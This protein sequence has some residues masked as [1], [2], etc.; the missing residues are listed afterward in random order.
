MIEHVVFFKLKSMEKDEE[1]DLINLVTSLKDKISSI[2]ELSFGRTFQTE[3]AKGYTHA[4][5]VLFESKKDLEE[6]GPN[7]DHQ[8][9]VV[10]LRKLAEDAPI[11]LDWERE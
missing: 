8:E 1:K 10:V 6:Y 9:V 4:I 2:K 5:R 11:C 7:K 3:R